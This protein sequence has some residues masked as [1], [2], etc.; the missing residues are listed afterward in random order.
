MLCVSRNGDL[1]RSTSENELSLFR[2]NS[3]D[4]SSSC[5]HHATPPTWRRQSQ[6]L[7]LH[8]PNHAFIAELGRN[9]R[10]GFTA[11]YLQDKGFFLIFSC[12]LAGP[13]TSINC[14]L[15]GRVGAASFARPKAATSSNR[16]D[17]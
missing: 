12:S 17:L 15:T 14:R 7:D 8:E 11:K 1:V 10:G 6:L 2:G 5:G 9:V 16:I 4:A 13:R 3:G